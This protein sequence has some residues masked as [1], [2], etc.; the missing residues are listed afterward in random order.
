MPYKMMNSEIRLIL[1][2]WIKRNRRALNLPLLVIW[3]E[4]AFSLWYDIDKFRN[5]V[6]IDEI[7]QTKPPC[8]QTL[9]LYRFSV[10]WREFA[11]PTLWCGGAISLWSASAFH[12]G[13]NDTG[14]G[15]LP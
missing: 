5:K 1:T 14:L 3:C 4:F 10:G 11:F 15:E 8:A 12:I 2:I 6:N 7:R 13:A 9:H